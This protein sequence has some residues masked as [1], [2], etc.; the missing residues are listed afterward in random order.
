MGYKI[1]YLYSIAMSSKICLAIWNSNY[2]VNKAAFKIAD[3]ITNGSKIDELDFLRIFF[4]HIQHLTYCFIN[5]ALINT[6]MPEQNWWMFAENIFEIHFCE[7]T[8]IMFS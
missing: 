5:L 4:S 1:F 2:L 3:V 7:L 8:V 6:L